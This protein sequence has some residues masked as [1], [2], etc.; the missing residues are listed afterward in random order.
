MLAIAAERM[1]GAT[2]LQGDALASPFADDS[3]D[4]ILTCHFYGHL[5][6]GQRETLLR[7]A[8]RVAAELVVV[9]ALQRVPETDEEWSPRVLEDGYRAGRCTSA[10][11]PG[12][13]PRGARRRRGAPRRALV[14]RRRS[15][16]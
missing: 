9:D 3:F 6:T 11:S 5:D 8:R 16:R 4:R 7:E 15:S 10:G 13:A 2:F 1:P 14:P 12:D